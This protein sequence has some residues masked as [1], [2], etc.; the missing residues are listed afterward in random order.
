MLQV[1]DMRWGVTDETMN[2]HQVTDLCLREIDV[3]KQSS[4]GP[5]FV[6]S[7]VKSFASHNVQNQALFLQICVHVHVCSINIMRACVG[8]LH[9]RSIVHLVTRE[10]RL[11]CNFN[12]ID[13]YLASSGAL[14][15]CVSIVPGR[16]CLGH[17]RVSHTNKCNKY[18]TS[19]IFKVNH[20]ARPTQNR[21]YN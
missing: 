6:V 14:V 5:Y 21:H 9:K 2:D 10:K 4:A 8:L 1:L 3:C 7:Y 17:K 15:R 19:Y 18:T 12:L 16:F 11:K 13:F 20:A